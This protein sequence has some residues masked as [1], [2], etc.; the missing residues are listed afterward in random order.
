LLTTVKK[1]IYLFLAISLGLASC[2]KEKTIC[3]E[4]VGPNAEKQTGRATNDPL[5]Y[6]TQAYTNWPETFESGTKTAYSN[7]AI[8]LI[9][10]IWSLNDALI[11][12]STSDRKTGTKSVRIQNS[13]T[14][15]MNFNLTNGATSVSVKHAKYGTDAN[16][17]WSLS[18]STNSGSTWTALGSTITTSSTALTTT[19]FS[20]NVTG[21]IRFRLTKLSGGRLNVDDFSVVDQGGTSGGGSTG[22]TPT[23]DNNLEMG[24]PSAA[25]NLATNLSNYLLSKSQY[26]MSYNNGRGCANWVSWH[27]SS[28]WKGAA[29]RCDC[30]ASESLL[31]TGFYKVPSTAYT[32]TG[33]DRGHL[34]ASDDRDGSATDNAATFTMSNMVPQAPANNQ[35]LWAN[36]E[37]YCRTLITAGNE[38]YVIS[39]AYGSGGTGSN[40]GT[41]TTI[42]SGRV[43]V[44]ARLWKIIVVLPVGTGDAA[45]VTSST[46]VIAINVPNTQ[47]SNNSTW[48]TYRTSVDAI[49]TATGYNFLSAVPAAVQSVLEA[50]TDAGPTQ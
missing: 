48:G 47:T 37:A 45:R 35:G 23:R 27:L 21:N 46:R 39:G 12:T 24:N 40:G 2:Q 9:T 13:G 20:L 19:S 16:S 43:T 32:N 4:L 15:E 18:Y 42:N 50:T 14:V 3:P 31:P 7:G 30:F 8:T 25:T 10:G 6:E 11:G 26:V 17:T 29:T 22:G 1:V 33:F 34:C 28:A 36:L 5:F 41:T 44:P 38:L 49:E